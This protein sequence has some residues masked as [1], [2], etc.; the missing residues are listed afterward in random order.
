MDELTTNPTYAGDQ[1]GQ[2]PDVSK[3]LESENRVIANVDQAFSVCE[4]MVYDWKKGITTSARITAKL[5]GERPYSQSKLKAA[6][7]DWK[8]NISTGFLATECARILPRLFM[9]IKT[10]KYLT[11]VALP[12]GWD[13]G[14]RKTEFFRQAVT[15]QIR[16]WPKFNFYIKGLAREVGIF[17]FGFN[18]FLEKYDWRP[19]L[20]RMDKGFVPMGTE[21]MEEPQFFMAKQDYKPYEL[22]GLLKESVDAGNTDWQKDNVVS[23]INNAQVPV[24]GTLME[25]SRSYEELIRQAAW[26]YNYSKGEKV[27]RAWHLLAKETTGKV[28]HYILLADNGTRAVEVGANQQQPM[29]GSESRL[30]YECLDKFDS[31]SDAVHTMVFDYGDGTVHGSWGA[32]QILYD[33]ATQ[34]EK[35]RCDAID[36]LR[37]T[38]KIKA[39]VPDAKNVN[40]VKLTVNGEMM[41][42]SGA[43]FAGN[44]AAMT[45]DVSG[46]EQLDA[47]LVQLAQEKIGAFVP[48][49]PLQNS[50]IKAA[51]I[52]AAMEKEKEIAEALLE[53]WLIQF[54]WLVRAM[55]RRLC[56][57]ETPDEDAKAFQQ[58]LESTL[59]KDEIKLLSNQM[60]IQSIIDY[61]ELRS[62]QRAAF[63]STVVGNPLFKQNMVARTMAEGVG[64]Q[65]FVESIVLPEGDQTDQIKAAHDQ[66]TENAA[67]VLNQPVPVLPTDLDWVHMQT[68]KPGIMAY[69]QQGNAQT[70]QIGLQHYAAH[71]AQGVEKKTIPKEQ[72]N[73]EKQWIAAVEKQLEALQQRAALQQHQQQLEA[74]AMRQAHQMIAEG[75]PAATQPT[76]QP[77]QQVAPAGGP[78][79]QPGA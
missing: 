29:P 6:G 28:S 2:P 7:K 37:M 9:P 42:I 11:A 38:N 22:F 74:L 48:P 24:N 20:M 55:T 34:V 67:L 45:V 66:M 51:Q 33:M 61:T 79:M 73:A 65:R 46:Y 50:D 8:T 70:A 30:L 54:A 49:I 75:H 35:V 43:Q 71:Y 14:A 41:I 13:Q 60:P 23:A 57:P 78:P 21:I 3:S 59:T 58:I 26:V 25:N 53:N 31:M 56:N 36:N 63:A 62:Q 77:P 18:T 47:R 44:Q 72:I 64:D 15:E 40:D 16:S 4:N 32:G 68:L 76:G 27:I 52:N 10:A 39:N 19:T 69:L 1:T 5:N 17:G 12:P